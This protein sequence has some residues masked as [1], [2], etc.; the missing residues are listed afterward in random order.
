M[1][2]ELQTNNYEMS[3]MGIGVYRELKKQIFNRQLKPGSRLVQQKLAKAMG[4]SPNTV[5]L[6]ITTAC[7][8]GFCGGGRA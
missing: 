2:S 6:R 8:N 5:H 1:L 7:A 4:V 3:N